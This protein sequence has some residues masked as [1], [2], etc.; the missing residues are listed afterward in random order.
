MVNLYEILCNAHEGH[1]LDNL[2]AQFN[3]TPA[4]A[5]AA[6]KAV[7]PPLSEHLLR[8][9]SEPAAFG[10]FVGALGEGQH[11]A[12]FRDPAAAQPDAQVREKLSQILGSNSAQEEIVLRASSATGLSESMLS[13]MVP[14]IAS[15]IFGGLAKSMQN[16]GFGGILGQLANAA[17]QGGL[18]PILGQVLGGGPAP[19][20][21]QP[22]PVGAPGP[23][24]GL[25]GLGEILGKILGAGQGRADPQ[26]PGQAPS[27]PAG[28]ILGSILES[29]TRRSGA[30]PAAAPTAGP[31]APAGLPQMPGFDPSSI[32]AS[33]EALIKMLQP[34]TGQPP[35][36]QTA[37]PPP[38]APP[39]GGLDINAELDR[40][41]GGK[42]Q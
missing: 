33:L 1:A 22:G 30:G 7:L 3:I 27:V 29:L 21:P 26:Q 6:V 39:A 12:A 19:A 5:D 11:L 40:I 35:S 4:E 8:Q 9:T 25:G 28:G 16:Q 42:R 34:G 17:G 10:S 24:G 23:A 14:V 32:Q 41:I 37:S 38:A 15:M 2:A 18:G 13:Q 20:S 36:P 31:S